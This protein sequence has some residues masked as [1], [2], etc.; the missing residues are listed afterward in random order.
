M[1]KETSLEVSIFNRSDYSRAKFDKFASNRKIVVERL[2][3]EAFLRDEVK[4]AYLDDFI[5]W[6]WLDLMKMDRDILTDA[7][8]L[9][10]FFGDDN[11]YDAKKKKVGK[12][13]DEFSTKVFGRDVVLNGELVN[14]LLGIKR[15][16]GP[17]VAP[18]NFNYLEACKVVYKD[19]NL[20]KVVLD[21]KKFDVDTRLLHL[22]LSHTINARQGG[23]ADVNKDDI[24]W[25]YHIMIGNPP[26]LGELMVQRMVRGVGWCRSNDKYH[27]PFGKFVSALIEKIVGTIPK[28]ELREPGI[29][30]AIIDAGALKQMKFKKIQESGM[31]YK[32]RREEEE[33]VE[34]EEE[35]V[36]VED[37]EGGVSNQMLM[38]TMTEGFARINA[39]QDSIDTWR[40]EVDM[41]RGNVDARLKSM[42]D[43]QYGR[44]FDGSGPSGGDAGN[45]SMDL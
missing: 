41:W 26:N 27:L 29:G 31:W 30:K 11:L 3:N 18:S 5:A 45:D 25:M 7:V 40:G 17:R 15:V 8:R 21:V 10:Y 28:D 14:D 34:E 32:P 37:E 12:L 13:K 39:W 24:F 2:W 35:E 38:Q 20:R 44:R 1:K 33:E 16:D 19:A 42:E 43:F 6:G 23:Y 22:M 36:N 9:F 4:F